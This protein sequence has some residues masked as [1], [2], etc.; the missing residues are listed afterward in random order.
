[1]FVRNAWYV[2]AWSDEI[3]PGKMLTR[4][5]LNEPVLFYRSEDGKLAALQDRCCHRGLPLSHGCVLGDQ[6]QCGYHGLT[7]NAQGTCVKVPGQDR[8]P[9]GAK[10]R[11]YPVVEKQGMA[12]IWMGE[13]ER[14]DPAGIVSHPYHDDPE[15]V[16]V[17]DCYRVEANYQLI[18]DNLMD[19]THVG[20][21]H[22][23]TIGGTP[24]AHSEALTTTTG[25]D[26][27]VRVERWML[28]SVP[29]PSYTNAHT[30]GT[31]RVDRW[32]EIEFFAPAIVRIHTGAVDVNTGAREGRREGGIKFQGLN[33]QTPET[34]SSTHYFW[35]GARNRSASNGNLQKKLL[36]GLS[37]TFAEDKVVVEA[38][39]KSL[40]RQPEPLVMIA[41]DAGMVRARR[42]VAQML[43][44][45]LG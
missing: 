38:Q 15:W 5:L 25:T 8:I 18:T 32:M 27:G 33:V 22:T 42:I 45:E 16:W 11:S 1:M 19:L 30:F 17:K 34:E 4:T 29:P 36:D 13:P 43:E 20:Y 3:T 10:V 9:P 24:E 14:A 31:E 39:Q 35:S 12:W 37:I 2:G 44:S 7:F 23:R 28:N 21:V 6:V 41:T 40:D 26:R